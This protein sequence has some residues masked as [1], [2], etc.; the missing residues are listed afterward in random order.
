MTHELHDL[1]VQVLGAIAPIV[2][3]HHFLG[4]ATQVFD[5]ARAP[6]N[7]RVMQGLPGQKT[8]QRRA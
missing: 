2:S 3:H 5:D 7:A 6:A 8:R 1:R 4:G